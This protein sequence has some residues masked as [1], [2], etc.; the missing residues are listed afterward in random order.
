MSHSLD[1]PS[2]PPFPLLLNCIEIRGKLTSHNTLKISK[3]S[4]ASTIYIN[5]LPYPHPPAK[6]PVC[7][8]RNL[9]N[10][11]NWPGIYLKWETERFINEVLE[12]PY[13]QFLLQSICSWSKTPAKHRTL[14]TPINAQICNH[15]HFIFTASVKKTASDRV[16]CPVKTGKP[17]ACFSI[18]LWRN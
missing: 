9:R 5:C 17:A 3:S 10:P 16:N 7:N 13:S 14:I 11:S 8:H 1:F 15:E 2:D 4:S 18:S 6:S 12:S